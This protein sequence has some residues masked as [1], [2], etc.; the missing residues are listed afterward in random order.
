MTGCL[1]RLFYLLRGQVRQ[2]RQIHASLPAAAHHIETKK[3]EAMNEFESAAGEARDAASKREDS[4]SRLDEVTSKA[5]TAINQ[6]IAKRRGP[7][8]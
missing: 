2:R 5:R 4:A 3:Q 7:Y 6:L 8:T 1:K